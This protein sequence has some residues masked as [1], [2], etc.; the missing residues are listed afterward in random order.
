MSKQSERLHAALAE[1]SERLKCSFFDACIE[2]CKENELD[3]ED[4]V[5]Q[6]DSF[7]IDRVKQSAIDDRMVSKKNSGVDVKQ[8]IF[9]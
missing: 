6:L 1:I 3:P 8:L 4:L 2:L 5:K 7:T 9:E